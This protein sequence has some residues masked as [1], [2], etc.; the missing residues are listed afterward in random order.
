VVKVLE[1]R[2]PQPP[3]TP[4]PSKPR[5]SSRGFRLLRL[6]ILMQ[7][8]SIALTQEIG[9]SVSPSQSEKSYYIPRV[10]CPQ[11][12]EH[13]RLARTEPQVPHN[14]HRMMFDCPCGFEYRMSERVRSRA[15]TAPGL[16]WTEREFLLWP[17]HECS[18]C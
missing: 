17:R 2:S 10:T 18:P 12:G 9:M 13:M 3:I 7:S 4:R 6:R 5:Y 8:N 16:T 14:H 11:C 1:G 15:E